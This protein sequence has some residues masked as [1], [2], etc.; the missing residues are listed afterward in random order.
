MKAALIVLTLIASS[1]APATV[2]VPPACSLSERDRTWIDRALEAWRF[3]SREITGI[4]SVPDFRAVFFSADCMLTSTNAFSS[5]SVED[6][7]WTAKPHSGEIV[8]PN[9]STMPAGVTSFASGDEGSYFF[10]MSTPTVWEAAGVGQGQSLETLMVAVMLHEGSH[11]A[12]IAPYGPRLG[13]LIERHSLPDSFSD[14]T[15]Q[16]VFRENAEFAASVK[17]ESELLLAAAQAEKDEEA[18]RLARE[19]GAIG[20]EIVVSGP[21]PPYHFVA[22]PPGRRTRA[23]RRTALVATSRRRRGWPGS[24]R[25]RCRSWQRSSSRSDQWNR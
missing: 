20:S 23:G 7:T 11:V 15:M 17:R 21:W 3:T 25:A 1:C 5:P 24:Y 8:L 13:A 6:V 18:K 14:D 12:Q 9:G 4:G 22:A 10:V 19:A 2:N 16:E